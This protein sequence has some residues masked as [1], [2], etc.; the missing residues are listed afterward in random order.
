MRITTTLLM[1]LFFLTTQVY[2][3]IFETKSAEDLTLIEGI[4]KNFIG[5]PI[6]ILKKKFP[7]NISK[8]EAYNAQ[9]KID[10]Y[11]FGQKL[12]THFIMGLDSKNKKVNLII[13]ENSIFTTSKGIKIGDTFKK[14]KDLHPDGVFYY[15]T[16]FSA[17]YQILNGSVVFLIDTTSIPPRNPGEDE[18]GENHP[19]FQNK[20]IIRII[21]RDK[22]EY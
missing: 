16:G 5:T 19:T 14:L 1:I 12:K 17:T 2:S 11:M 22:I 3:E 15:N 10:R 18:K 21:I 4:G 13:L 6:S 8:M 7:S 20:R 9:G